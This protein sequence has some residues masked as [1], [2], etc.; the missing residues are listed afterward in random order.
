L[1][2]KT[3]SDGNT[4]WTKSF[5]GN[6]SETGRSVQQ[7]RDGG[8]IIT[9]YTDSFSAGL[10]DVWLIKT[11]ATGDTLFTETFG[12]N[13]SDWGNFVQQTTDNGFVITGY[14]N[15]DV[16]L[17][18]TTLDT[19]IVA[20]ELTS[21]TA[22]ISVNEIS[23]KWTTATETNNYGFKILRFT[24]NDNDWEKIG[25]VPGFGTTTEVHHY[26]FVDEA[27]KP[28]NYLYR[29][30]QVDYDGSYEY[31]AVMELEW[32]AFNSYLLEQ[33]YPNPFNPT[34]TIGFGIQ[35]KS[36]VKI[37]ILNAI[38]EEVPVILNEEREAGF[39]QVEFNAE[40]LPS[41]VYFY[42]LKAGQYVETKKMVLMK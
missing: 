35:N 20:V 13:S 11:N 6:D 33:C 3:D 10:E 12:G 27:L 7:T 34:T 19:A 22:T 26:S 24:Q 39:H 9:G 36:N 37:T 17:I 28:G 16:W 23:L 8:Y 1:L 21:F 4:I 30:K 41:G 25:F 29:L 14:T 32:K 40:N 15:G 18:K 5:G 42:Q 2:I 38:G 31:S